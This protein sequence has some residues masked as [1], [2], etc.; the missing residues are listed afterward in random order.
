MLEALKIGGLVL[1]SATKFF[2]APA[3]IV[4][5]GYDFWTTILITCLGGGLGFA[6]FFR[7]GQLI[8]TAIQH[9]FKIKPKKKFTKRNKMIIKL[10]RTYGLWGLAL[11]TPCFLGIPIGAILASI[12]YSKQKGAIFVFSLFIFVWAFILTSFSIY[13]KDY[14]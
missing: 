2:F 1:F 4:L 5:A 11:L 13:I 6:F 9:F 10:K 14:S 12:Y 7:F 3:A 8:R